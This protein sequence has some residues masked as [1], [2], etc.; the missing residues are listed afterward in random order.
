MTPCET[1]RPTLSDYAFGLLDAP[2][3]ATVHAHL[4]DCAD[5]RLALSE[6]Q[7]LLELSKAASSA[8]FPVAEFV[9]PAEPSTLI[10]RR[11]SR[12]EWTR[13]VVAASLILGVA[14]LIP[15]TLDGVRIASRNQDLAAAQTQAERAETRL[16]ATNAELAVAAQAN[17]K[18]QAETELALDKIAGEWI[19]AETQ[20]DA[21]RVR[22]P[23]S[24][25]AAASNTFQLQGFEAARVQVADARGVTRF[26]QVV[27]PDGRVTLPASMW[28][29]D[30]PP[31]QLRIES[32]GQVFERKL[33]QPTT[34]TH[35]SID[36]ASY[37]PGETVYARSL[38]LDRADFRPPTSSPPVW[39][40][41]TG[42]RGVVA[43]CGQLAQ[44]RPATP[45]GK[46]VLGPDGKPVTGIGTAILRL[47]NDLREGDYQVRVVAARGDGPDPDATP[48]TVPITIARTKPPAFDR[49][50]TFDRASFGPGEEV[51]GSLTLSDQGVPLTQ[52]SV[53]LNA[54]A[55]LGGKRKVIAHKVALKLGPNGIALFAFKLPATD[56]SS[57]ELT[58]TAVAQ[59][60]T[61][62]VRQAVPVTSPAVWL[63]AFPEGGDAIAGIPGRVY[64]RATGA[65]GKPADVAGVM[66]DAGQRSRA[67]PDNQRRRPVHLDT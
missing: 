31:S 24:A 57:A 47:P 30:S 14:S 18:R 52:A 67:I 55:I 66:F 34:A 33:T 43:G 27:P 42:P 11:T 59:G 54:H 22:G 32:D 63:E 37:Q 44:T 29:W 23:A 16:R 56:L 58:L 45:D 21:R 50:V 3:L 20:A 65:N 19:T 39:F 4:N 53:T 40:D 64:L 46:P 17:Q 62:W 25:V 49:V 7:R 6:S 15:A 5:C 38:T 26:N 61:E 36:R 9:P 48:T 41:I 60:K 10:V 28:G 13:W 35:L 12:A 1:C 51:R 2:E 8:N